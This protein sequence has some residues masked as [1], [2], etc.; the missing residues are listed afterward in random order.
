VPASP[1]D[2]SADYYLRMA[3]TV[4]ATGQ[5][6]LVVNAD[7]LAKILTVAAAAVAVAEARDC[8]DEIAEQR[9]RRLLDG[10]VARLRFA[11]VVSTVGGTD[12]QPA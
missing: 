12:D 8:R 2:R 11:A 3:R 5:R 4:K 7:D 9:S 6:T 1:P 10:A